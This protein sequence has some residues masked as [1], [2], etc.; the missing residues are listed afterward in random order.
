MVPMAAKR[1]TQLPLIG[2]LI[3]V[4]AALLAIMSS[5]LEQASTS[6]SESFF[7]ADAEEKADVASSAP[8]M[9]TI[10][11]FADLGKI[12]EQVQDAI[13]S[14]LPTPPPA[15]EEESTETLST[16]T[17][18]PQAS[19]PV[20][21]QP[22]YDTP[23]LSFQTISENTRLALVN[24]LCIPEDSSLHASSGSGVIIDS[25]GVI[26]TNAHVAQYVLLAQS[27]R[28]NLSCV[29]R[30]GAPARVIGSAE[31]LFIPPA[32]VH[33]NAAKITEAAPIGTGE[34]DYALLRI[35]SSHEARAPLPYSFPALPIDIRKNAGL[36]SDAVL[37]ASYPSEFVGAQ[38]TTY[39]LYPASS[40]TSIRRLLTFFEDTVDLLSLAGV[41]EAQSGSSGGAIVNGWN[42][43]IGVI[44][45]V[46]EGA[47]TAEREMRAITLNYVNRDL[48]AE[49]GTS[50]ETFLAGELPSLATN[51]RNAHEQA[52]AEL[53]ISEI[54][55]KYAR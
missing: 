19:S 4:V 3:V 32:W 28:T 13:A 48:Q 20:R 44:T 50:L 16:P 1:E 51:F 42:Y 11:E 47:T 55:K 29:V 39:S 34:N 49:T 31:V 54:D 10:G 41:Q 23:P 27:G 14:S 38:A 35:I 37:A 9:N 52:L 22:L 2:G 7:A 8:L 24:I 46:S 18:S 30:Q 21:D 15:A 12:A 17:P 40:I 33:A 26:L 43:L 6:S 5:P 53:L 45:S 25:R 36:P